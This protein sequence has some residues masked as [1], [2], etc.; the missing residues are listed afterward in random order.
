[1]CQL[2][3]NTGKLQ[4]SRRSKANRKLEKPDESCTE[5]S[6]A[7]RMY[8]RS[9]SLCGTRPDFSV[10]PSREI[11]LSRKSVMVETGNPISDPA[12]Q[13]KFNLIIKTFH[14]PSD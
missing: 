13:Q 7:V 9:A 14:L 5:E 2:T 3:A 1:L 6:C 4:K 8:P 11:F 12:Q 10:F